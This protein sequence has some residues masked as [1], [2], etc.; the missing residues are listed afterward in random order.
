MIEGIQKTLFLNGCLI[1][2]SLRLFR[3]EFIQTESM[4]A[5]AAPTMSSP[6]ESPTKSVSSAFTFKDSRAIEKIFGEDIDLNVI[7]L[8]DFLDLPE[9]AKNYITIRAANLFAGRAVGSTESVKFSSREE[10]A[11]RAALIEYETQQGDYSMLGN[12]L[13]EKNVA[14]TPY[15]ALTR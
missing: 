14:Y 5:F 12:T 13:N 1:I 6:Q 4:P 8:F 11:A 9:T 15:N 10:G 3:F 7:W 2:F